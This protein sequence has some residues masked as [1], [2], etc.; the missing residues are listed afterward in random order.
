M[1]LEMRFGK[2]QFDRLA[3]YFQDS[4]PTLNYLTLASGIHDEL[5]HFWQELADGKQVEKP[6]NSLMSGTIWEIC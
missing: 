5:G 2:R 6:D 4:R 1:E 3:S